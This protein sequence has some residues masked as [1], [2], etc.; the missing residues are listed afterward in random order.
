M[1]IVK[2]AIVTVGASETRLFGPYLERF[3]RTM[4]EY[5]GADYL[6]IWH[7]E[8]PPGSPTH[9]EA[10][11]AFKVH[12]V[13]ETAARGYTSILW[14]DCSANAFKPIEPMWERLERDGHVLVEDANMLGK[15]CGDRTLE[16]FGV[17]R[18]KAMTIPLMCGTCWGVDLT[19]ERSRVFLERLRSYRCLE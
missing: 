6:K 4:R 18:D 5:G 12:A 16:V 7:K 9:H 14:L 17:S 10:H 2:R 19:V 3:K 15:W 8:W 1:A 13:Y 11:Y